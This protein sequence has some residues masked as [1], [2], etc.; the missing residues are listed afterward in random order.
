M[1]E[2]GQRLLPDLYNFNC[3]QQGK[4]IR[5]PMVLTLIFKHRTA[6]P[7]SRSQTADHKLIFKIFGIRECKN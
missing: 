2:V 1:D 6:F 3:N 7:P 5:V 4:E